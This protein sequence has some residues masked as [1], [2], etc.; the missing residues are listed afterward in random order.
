M[1]QIAVWRGAVRVLA[2]LHAVVARFAEWAGPYEAGS[3][4]ALLSRVTCPKL[5][6]RLGGVGLSMPLEDL[7]IAAFTWAGGLAEDN[8]VYVGGLEAIRIANSA[9]A[10]PRFEPGIPAASLWRSA[11]CRPS[12][13]LKFAARPRDARAATLDLAAKTPLSPRGY[14]SRCREIQQPPL[15]L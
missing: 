6:M 5:L 13:A 15:P 1:A 2:Q 14:R 11:E 3:D 12:K 9:L 4:C 10:R 7:A 8:L